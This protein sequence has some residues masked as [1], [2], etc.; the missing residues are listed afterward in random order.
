MQ[1][2]VGRERQPPQYYQSAEA[3]LTGAF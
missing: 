1:V 3:L 2:H